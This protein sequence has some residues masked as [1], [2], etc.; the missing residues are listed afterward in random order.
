M[1]PFGDKWPN[2]HGCENCDFYEKT[3]ASEPEKAGG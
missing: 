2:M 1:V 3:E